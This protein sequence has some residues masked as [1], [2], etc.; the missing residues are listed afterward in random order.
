M[1][2]AF[3]PG[4]L[5]SKL[6]LPRSLANQNGTMAWEVP[7]AGPFPGIA[8]H[9]VQAIGVALEAADRGKARMAVGAVGKLALPAVGGVGRGSIETF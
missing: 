1:A 3:A 2:R 5:G 8:N 7:R 4:R 9:V 6:G